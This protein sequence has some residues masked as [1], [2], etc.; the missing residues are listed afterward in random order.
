[1]V[2][3]RVFSESEEQIDFPQYEQV[4]EDI[5]ANHKSMAREREFLLPRLQWRTLTAIAREGYVRAP[6]SR[7]FVDKYHLSAPSSMSRAVKAL[8]DKGLIIDCGDK[9]LRVYNV[10][11]EK[12]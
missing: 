9:G 7:A 12:C 6:Q 10:F 11:I 2:L 5:L 3:S 4:W 8:L 1:M